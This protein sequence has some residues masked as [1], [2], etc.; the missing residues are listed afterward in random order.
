MS[1][2]QGEGPLWTAVGNS[3]AIIPNHK[4][5]RSYFFAGSRLA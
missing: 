5:T 1:K 2:Y 4:P 3:A